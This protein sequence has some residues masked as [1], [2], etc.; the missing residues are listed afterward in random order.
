MCRRSLVLFPV[1]HALALALALALAV[2]LPAPAN[3]QR[4]KCINRRTAFLVLYLVKFG[5]CGRMMGYWTGSDLPGDYRTMAI[6]VFFVRNLDLE[7]CP[8]SRKF[9][10]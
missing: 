10:Q 8:I 9:D 1:V 3:G 7:D 4:E 5:T 6:V 2:E